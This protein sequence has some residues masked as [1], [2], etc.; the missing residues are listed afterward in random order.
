MAH[1]QKARRVNCLFEPQSYGII[2]IMKKYVLPFVVMFAIVFIG[3]FI[4][5]NS[6]SIENQLQKDIRRIQSELPVKIDSYTTNI[7]ARFD[8]KTVS[9]DF[10]IEGL[11]IPN[12]EAKKFQSM[13]FVTNIFAVCLNET[14]PKAL[15][16]GI[17][18]QYNYT[19]ADSNI[20]FSNKISKTDCAP[21][22]STNNSDLGQYYVN[23]Q[24]NALPMV[25]DEETILE[26]IQGGSNV[27]TFNHKLTRIEISALDLEFFTNYIDQ[28]ILPTFCDTP[29]F[30]ALS[31]RGYQY[32]INYFDMHQNPVYSKMLNKSLCLEI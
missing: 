29:D 13:Q 10:T 7:A 28:N 30:K 23:L 20:Q 26:T 2:E 6:N 24:R 11:A 19:L 4:T 22:Q 14:L 9:Y 31:D 32:R 1:F 17:S 8:N 18:I 3:N 12:S 27:L 16:A 21:F 5:N 25:L 15:E